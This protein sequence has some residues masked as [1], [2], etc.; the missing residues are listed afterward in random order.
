[1]MALGSD[2]A[3][4][5]VG[6]DGDKPRVSFALTNKPFSDDVWFHNQHLVASIVMLGGLYGDDH[7]TYRLP[8]VPE[9]NELFARTM[10]F[11]YDM[12]RVEPERTGLI[13]RTTDYDTFLSAMPVGQLIEKIFDQAGLRSRLS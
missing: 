8:Y 13:I 4:G 7:H 5:V 2:S 3:L 9:L 11:E 1:M 10:H 12:L 6:R